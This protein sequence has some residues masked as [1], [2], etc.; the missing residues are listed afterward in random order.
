MQALPLVVRASKWGVISLLSTTLSR[1]I[2]ITFFLSLS[3]L[4]FSLLPH[5]PPLHSPLSILQLHISYCQ[6]VRLKCKA[7]GSS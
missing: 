7:F 6:F 4:S 1:V 5:P 2:S 3:P